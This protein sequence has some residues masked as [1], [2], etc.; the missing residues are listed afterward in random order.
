MAEGAG[1]NRLEKFALSPSETFAAFRSTID[2]LE[3]TC[4]LE[5][6][7]GISVRLQELDDFRNGYFRNLD[8]NRRRH[9]IVR[10]LLII[11]PL[12]KWWDLKQIRRWRRYIDKSGLFDKDWYAINYPDV[13]NEGWEPITH[14]LKIGASQGYNPSK[15]F[16]TFSYIA[17][18][19]KASFFGINP[20]IL[21]LR[22]RQREDRASAGSRQKNIMNDG[23]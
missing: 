13:A 7:A 5:F 14:Y 2:Y 17:A 9:D 23:V 12:K 22:T 15:E 8:R 19:P 6:A 21:Y 1:M 10:I 11:K 20:F 18:H 4:Q 3:E 16:D